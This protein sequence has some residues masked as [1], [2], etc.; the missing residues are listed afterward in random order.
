MLQDLST[1]GLVCATVG[2]SFHSGKVKKTIDDIL[3]SF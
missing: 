1:W 2:F 3:N